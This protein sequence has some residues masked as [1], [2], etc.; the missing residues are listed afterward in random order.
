MESP[1]TASQISRWRV[2]REAPRAVQILQ[3][4]PWKAQIARAVQP[5][6]QRLL[7]PWVW[8]A[9][10]NREAAGSLFHKRAVHLL[11]RFAPAGCSTVQPAEEEQ[12]RQFPVSQGEPW[13]LSFPG[14]E[15]HIVE[16][17]P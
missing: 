8:K 11:A 7:A 16:P 4:S 17:M 9:S 13:S 10:R 14:H 1:L 3:A 5:A 15:A 2:P 6:M 12:G